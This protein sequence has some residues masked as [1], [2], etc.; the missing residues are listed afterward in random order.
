MKNFLKISFS[1]TILLVALTFTGCNSDSS[2]IPQ[3]SSEEVS[4]QIEKQ[5]QQAIAKL[6]RDNA[7]SFQ[8]ENESLTTEFGDGFIW[9]WVYYREPGDE[10]CRGSGYSFVKCVK[11]AIDSGLTLMV[12]QDAQTGDYVATEM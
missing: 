5:I 7:L 12:Y 3:T 9:G 2:E 4:N 6:N 11:N 10:D 8:I 1:L